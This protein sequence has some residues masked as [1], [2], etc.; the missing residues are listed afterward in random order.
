MSRAPRAPV[1]VGVLGAGTVGAALVRLLARHPEITITAAL[2]RDPGRPRDLGLRP[3]RLTTDPDEAIA[4]ADVVVELLGGVEWPT[5]LMARAAERGA[6][7]VTANKAALAEA[8]PTWRPWI[9]AGRVGF[10]AAVMAG[11]PAI[12]P[13]TGAL[14]GSRMRS[15]EAVLNGT[16]AYLIGELERGVDFETA[17]AEAQ[18]LGFAEADPSLDVDG[19]DAAHKVAVVARMTVAP[20][21][22]WTDVV[23]R[24]R[25]VR[26]LTPAGVRAEHAA[27]RRVRLVAYVEP[28]GAGG[29]RVGVEPRSIDAERPLAFLADGRNALVYRGDAVGEVWIAGPGAGADVTASAVLADVLQAARGEPGPRPAQAVAS[30]LDGFRPGPAGAALPHA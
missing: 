11:T 12:G 16:C 5:A 1:R 6:R 19:W 4:G 9:E 17:L 23:P 3:P 25:G 18:R 13:L 7:L 28:D 10:E 2:V 20:D 27:G 22:A 26:G 21:L 30:P 14:R 29:W 8:W 15:L 24:V